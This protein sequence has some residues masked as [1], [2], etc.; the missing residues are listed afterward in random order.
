MWNKSKN[1]ERCIIQALETY[2]QILMDSNIGSDENDEHYNYLYTKLKN[3]NWVEETI[4]I[5]NFPYRLIHGARVSPEESCHYGVI[6]VLIDQEGQGLVLD[7]NHRINTLKELQDPSFF[8]IIKVKG[9]LPEK[10]K[11]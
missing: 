11:L 8:P 2:H 5:D 6:V 1:Y 4:S 3:Q 9:F 10:I 7:G